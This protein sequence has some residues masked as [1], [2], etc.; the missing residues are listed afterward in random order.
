M[1]GWLEPT[2][3]QMKDAR[4]YLAGA[5][6]DNTRTLWA[7]DYLGARV[8]RVAA[9]DFDHNDL[10]RAVAMYRVYEEVR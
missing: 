8:E 7:L 2:P 6:D 1:T 5:F 3:D 10:R 4:S 9:G